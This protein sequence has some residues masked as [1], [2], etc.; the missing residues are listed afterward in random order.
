MYEAFNGLSGFRRIVNDIVIYDSVAT[1][2]ASHVQEFLN[3]R[4]E[5]KITLNLEKC[6]FSEPSVTFA[7]F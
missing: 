6:K 3:R 1:Q 4:A 5:R 7:G 2:H